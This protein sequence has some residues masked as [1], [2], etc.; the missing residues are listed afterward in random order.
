MEK[1][2]GKWSILL[3]VI[4][5]I[6]SWILIIIGENVSYL[7]VSRLMIGISGGFFHTTPFFVS[8]ISEVRFVGASSKTTLHT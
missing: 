5:S 1:F 4:P 8:E 7:I 2:G 3:M 6:A